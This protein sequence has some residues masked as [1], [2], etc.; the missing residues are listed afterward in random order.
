MT[1]DAIILAGGLGTRLRSAVSELPKCMAPVAARPFLWYL[2]TSL[3]R[4]QCVGRVVLSVGYLREVIFSWID[5]VRDEFPFEI[6]YAVEETPLGTGGGIRLA[7]DQCQSDD[8]LV[9]NG[10]TMYDVDLPS[11]LQS[12]AAFLEAAITLALKP[13][14]HFD[15][16][17]TVTVGADGVITAFREKCPCE[18]GNINGGVYVVR[19]SKLDMSHL[20]EKF[21]FEK[22]VLEPHVAFR[23]LYAVVQEGYFIDIGIPDDYRKAQYEFLVR[24]AEMSD[25]PY[26]TLLLDRD[27]T[28]NVLRPDDYVKTWDEFTFLPGFLEAAPSLGRLFR[29]ICIVTNQRGIGRGRMTETDLADIHAHMCQHLQ[30]IGCH[31]DDIFYCPAVDKADPMRKPQTGMWEELC[32]RHP[33]VN[34]SATVM[35]GDGDCDR[36]FAHNCGIDFIQV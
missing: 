31:I 21:S 34:A 27:G 33:E 12:H 3:K 23:D 10:D 11:L 18:A 8:V 25:F 7:L 26:D 16:Y 17:G 30:E 5:E 2:L 35:I 32:R 36:D 22:E 19:R 29:R 24:R 4:Q 1:I 13:M 9:L 15:R 6:T 20:P 14:T 28:I